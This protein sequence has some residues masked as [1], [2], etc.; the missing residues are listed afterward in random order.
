MY[1]KNNLVN[2][3]I[4]HNKKIFNKKTS[5]LKNKKGIFLLEFNGWQGVQIANSY[6]INSIQNIQNHNIV[7]FESFK[8]FEKKKGVF[9][10]NLKWYLGSNLKIKNFGIYSSFG[11]DKFIGENAYKKF[12]NKAFKITEKFFKKKITKKMVENFFI[13]NIWIGDLIY[14]SYLKKYRCYTIDTKSKNFKLFFKECV[15]IFL[16]WENF[17]KQNKIKGISVTH[18]VYTNA[19]PLRI[20]LKN[21]INAFVCVDNKLFKIDKKT[22]S[23]RDKTNGI[24]YQY[25]CLRK[26]FN[27]LTINE[28]KKG[29][30]LGKLFLKKILTGKQKYFYFQN[31]NKIKKKKYFF[32]KNG[33]KKIVIFMHSLLDS[34][35]VFGNFIFPDFYEWYKYLSKISYKTDYDWYI[36][37]HP[38]YPEE[39]QLIRNL[40][41]NDKNIKLLDSKANNLDLVKQGLSYALT[42]FGSCAAELSYLGV[43]V[44]NAHL[45][46]PHIKYKFSYS[47]KN[48]LDYENKILNF[49]KMKLNFDKKELYEYHFM[50]NYYFHNEYIFEKISNLYK[51]KNKKPVIYSNELFKYWLNNFSIE[52]HKKI[53]NVFKIFLKSKDYFLSRKHTALS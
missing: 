16:Y 45:H 17:F 36:K 44:I 13:N 5:N 51:Q 25:K 35:H 10:D 38:N 48:L 40:I 9:L 42:V 32:N 33:K 49:K 31:Q 52:K 37:P 14:D 23:F 29:L 30:L 11:V 47:A 28:K 6:L 4:K 2:K 39:E 20:A 24:D 7:A 12:E 8:I 34:P 15:E 1:I 18:S 50:N 22:C 53:C 3:F 41:K 27:K 19:I 26:V 46:N 21:N 43:K